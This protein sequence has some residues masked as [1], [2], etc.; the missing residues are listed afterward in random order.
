V[1]YATNPA[2]HPRMGT[3]A[4]RR[5]EW[6]DRIIRIAGLLVLVA[7][8]F[9]LQITQAQAWFYVELTPILQVRWAPTL[10]LFLLVAASFFYVVGTAG[11]AWV[12]SSGPELVVGDS[13]EEDHD[14]MVLRLRVRMRGFGTVRPA[15]FV[16]RVVDGDGAA[17]V[18]QAQM[19]IEL[20]WSHTP[21][22]MRP[23]VSRHVAATVGVVEAIRNPV[24]VFGSASAPPT[25]PAT[26]GL[27][28]HGM[29]H[30]P[31]VDPF[32][33]VAIQASV[34]IP[35]GETQS[36]RFGFVP[37]PDIRMTYRAAT[38]RANRQGNPLWP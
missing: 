15:A 11:A 8:A 9:G 13:L 36:R 7:V 35:G 23:E 4:G 14:V 20:Q 17:L 31:V 29:H 21:P 33:R 38:L 27:R 28:V 25:R 26:L 6:A 19:P 12:R 10:G 18:P 30:A 22:G 32:P 1:T 16:E 3:P 37:V 34:T 5:G 24:A 2:L